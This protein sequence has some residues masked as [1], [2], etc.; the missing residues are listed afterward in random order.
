MVTCLS[1]K[2]EIILSPILEWTEKDVWSFLVI[3]NVPTNPLYKTFKRV[4]CIL[5]PMANLHHKKQ[6]LLKYPYVKKNG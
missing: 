4:G 3:I 6:N 1:G 5:C 2:D